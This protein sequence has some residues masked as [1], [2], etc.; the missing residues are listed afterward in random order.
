[1]VK[2]SCYLYKDREDLMNVIDLLLTGRIEF[3][4]AFDESNIRSDVNRLQWKNVLKG[5]DIPWLKR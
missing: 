2:N 5:W 1:M 3:N 4:G